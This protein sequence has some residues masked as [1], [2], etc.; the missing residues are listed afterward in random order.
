M[1]N[2]RHKSKSESEVKPIKYRW[3]KSVRNQTAKWKDYC[4]FTTSS[5]PPSRPSCSR[6][7]PG[8]SHSLLGRGSSYSLFNVEE[9]I[10]AGK[11]YY[12]SESLYFYPSYFQ[13]KLV[14]LTGQKN[15]TSGRD[16][17]HYAEGCNMYSGF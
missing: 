17:I 12:S 2:F 5:S 4:P 6:T 14:G 10:P 7:S 8:T 1:T 13:D 11:S 15:R 3:G 16:L 9:E